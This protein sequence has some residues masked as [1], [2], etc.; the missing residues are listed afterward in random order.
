[1]YK[2][3]FRTTYLGIKTI[4]LHCL[5]MVYF[6]HTLESIIEQEQDREV[7]QA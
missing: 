5:I 3:P 1:M 2:Y 4:I 7:E 6:M